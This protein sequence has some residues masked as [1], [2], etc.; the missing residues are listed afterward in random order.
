M[1]SNSLK[2]LRFGLGPL[3][4][5]SSLALLVL[6][7]LS[8]PF[9]AFSE[10][11]F[12]FSTLGGYAGQ[13]NTD[14]LGTNA[15]ITQPAGTAVDSAGNIYISDFNNNTIRK[16]SMGMVTTFAGS[17]GVAGSFDA[18]GTNA[19]FNGPE[20]LA[21][22]AAGNVYVADSGNDTIRKI[23][24]GGAVTT[25]A[26]SPGI[27]GSTN[28]T[29]TNALF[30]A[31]AGVA[32]DLS[33]NVYVADYGNHVIRKITPAGVVSTLAGSPGNFGSA[34]GTGSGALF[35]EPEG[36]AVDSLGNVYVADTAN[37]M[38]R[39]ISPAGVVIPLAGS[40]GNYG[41]SN[42]IGTNA[43]FSSPQSVSVDSLGNVYVADT[44]NNLIR[45][46]T[47]L[48]VVSTV[49]GSGNP[50]S[51]DGAGTNAQFWGPVGIAV[52]G[53]SNVY[54]AD[55]LNGTVRKITSSGIVSTL[56]GSASNGRTDGPDAAARFSLTQAVAVDS[57][58]N[59]YV[60][61]AAN[62]TIRK[63]NPA[64]TV[65]TFAGSPG[66]AGSANGAGTNAQFYAPQ[67]VAVDSTGN[68]Y[69][70]DTLNHI[71]REITPSGNVSTLAGMAG[72][73]NNADGSGTNA[74]FDAPQ[75]IAVDKA[76]NVYVA[77]TLN[78]TIRVITPSGTVSTLA[79]TANTYGS[80][81]GTNASA[82]FNQPKGL[83]LDSA[84]NIYVTDSMN[85]TVRKITP[86]GVVTTLAGM[87]GVWGS[88]DGTNSDARFFEPDGV[89]VDSSGNVY[90]SDSG[91]HTIRKIAKTGTNWVV[92]T[93][94]GHAGTAGSV[95]G[96]ETSALFFYPAGIA[97]DSSGN[98]YIAD[99]GNDTVRFGSMFPA[100]SV[101]DLS[102]QPRPNSAIITWK[103]GMPATTRLLYGLTTNYGSSST[104]DS[105]PVTN[106]AVLLTGLYPSNIYYI[107]AVS[108]IGPVQATAN[109]SFSTDPTIVMLSSN[110]T[111]LGVWVMDTSAP[112]RYS[113][114]YYY[115]SVAPAAPTAQA[116][117]TPNIITPAQYDVYFWY[118]EGNNRSQ[119]AP[120]TVA[121]QN[122][123]S[124]TTVN[125]SI[126][127]GNWHLLAS[128]ETFA[129]G[130]S[131]FVRL[132]NYTGESNKI[133][134]S[135]AVKWVYTPGQD[136]PV[137]GNVP[138]WWANFYYGTNNI[139]PSQLAANGY[140][141]IDDYILGISPTDPNARLNFGTR[142]NARNGFQAIFSPYMGGRNYQLQSATNL[143]N[144]AWQTI[145]NLPLTQDTNGNGII[146]CTNVN[147]NSGATF[148]RL[149]VQLTN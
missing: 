108:Q 9:A 126:N 103:T 139:N 121:Y 93:I 14:G 29:G 80:T 48:G 49:A 2:N 28:G 123:S 78:H 77:D 74:Q 130:T 5:G 115:A 13:Q 125:E 94:G 18:T 83:A 95:D 71:I 131:G 145:A 127:G 66:V 67:A 7:L 86:A 68:V 46:I 31:P 85:D 25:F 148:Y 4:A 104:I 51:V 116:M 87:A 57:S 76:G 35:Y 16:I 101:Y 55:Y 149:S 75:G 129:A 34:N 33:S 143:L 88:A 3:R 17:P 61:D 10:N 24:P 20:G 124:S 6:S 47:P 69:V 26:G 30:D 45:K 91:N 102:I 111:Y 27:A 64:G 70:A 73:A 98:A 119:F 97:L 138:G 23:T 122:A 60:A 36:V 84:T 99:S 42:A 21:V 44:G 146:T 82:Q 58:S 62:N 133:V 11:V 12:N 41:S 63:I 1:K 79:G 134:I 114:Y 38:I 110:A 96:F 128:N 89:A 107:E 39:E 117:F 105:T 65:S 120:V 50:G 136:L 142:P 147:A 15:F 140:S 53:A 81:D 100:N 37:D 92:S 144:P 32:V 54:V 109:S 40:A 141:I 43:T 19:L 22:D 72:Y 132:G 90:V 137:N 118:S 113:Q 52:D 112:D 59:I 106:H 8:V 56:A 135:D